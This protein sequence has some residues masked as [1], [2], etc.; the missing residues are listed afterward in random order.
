[1]I[2]NEINA[3]AYEKVETALER[4]GKA[5]V[6]HATGTGKSCIA[7]KLVESH[8]D[9]SFLWLVSG[10]AR[11]TL[12]KADVTRYNN[13]T[14]PPN[15]QLCDCSLLAEATAEQWIALAAKKPDYLIFDCYHELTA[16]CWAKSAQQLL[17][18]CPQ[19]KL[20][21][22]TVPNSTEKNCQAAEELFGD[23]VVSR[24][25]VGE[26]MA[27]G[28]LPVP[29]NYVAMLW[30]QEGQLAQL[31]ARIKNLH[32]PAQTNA[33]S[34]QY[35]EISWS[36][37]QAENPAALMPRVLSDTQGRYL[38]VFESRDY[39]ETIRDELEHFLSSVDPAVRFYEADSG[40][41]TDSAA[42]EPFCSDTA[43]GPKVLLCVNAP[44]V[45]Q[46]L[47]G[48]AGVILVRQSSLMSTFKQMLCRALV[49]AGSRSVP[50]FDLVAQ[51]EG[52]GNGR[53]LQRDCTRKSG[54]QGPQCAAAVPAPC[55]AFPDRRQIQTG[56][57]N[58]RWYR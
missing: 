42:W 10:P 50:V 21:G 26:A 6:A 5:T 55:P 33:L 39:L 38:A 46:P 3:A 40:C 52:L 53:T 18:L 8:P 41:L 13:G 17:R 27:V 48:L 45:Q 4:S 9:R 37:R 54:R 36:V 12:R 58:G 43:P 35:E 34:A 28:T 2:L 24:M 22:L 47:E 20:L 23:A 31:R 32:L 29:S 1:M 44:G 16:A 57:D 19:A 51:F 56:P 49:A 30:P 15:L 14:L 25:T 11:M 7:W